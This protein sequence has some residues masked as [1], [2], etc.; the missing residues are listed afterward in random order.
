[1]GPVISILDEGTMVF[2]FLAVVA[3]D[4]GGNVIVAGR[5]PVLESM[6]AVSCGKG[7]ISSGSNLM[8]TVSVPI[9]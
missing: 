9:L 4:F 6:E 8:M 5:R 7:G 1:M 2:G 3:V